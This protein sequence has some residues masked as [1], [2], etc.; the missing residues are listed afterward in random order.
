MVLAREEEDHNRINY[1][2]YVTP[3]M[4]GTA[5]D[6]RFRAK[7]PLLAWL[8]TVLSYRPP[9]FQA[10]DPPV[11]ST[12]K[13][14]PRDCSQCYCGRGKTSSRIVGGDAAD[15]KEYP[16]IVMLLYRG[17]FY[18]GGS[19]IN[20][21]YILTAAHCVLSFTPSQLLA[22]LYD[23]EHSE[24]VTR[25]IVKLY[26]HE[27]FSLDTF[28]NDIAL[29]KLQQPVDVGG[30]F[31]AICLPVNGRTYAGH[32]GTV[33]GWGKLGNGSLSQ[34]LQKAVVPIMSNMQCR[35]SNYRASRITDN[36]LCA[37]YAEGGRD[38]CQCNSTVH[39]MDLTSE[40]LT[41]PGRIAWNESLMIDPNGFIGKAPLLNSG[42]WTWITTMF[43]MPIFS[44]FAYRAA[45]RNCAPCSCGTNSN[46]SKIVGG[47]EAE[48]G[49]YPW[50]VALYY[51]NRFI[52]GGSLINDRYVLTAAHCVFGS[53][54]SR[55]RVKFLMHDRTEPKEDSFER[56]VSYI[57]T[58]WFLNVLVFITNDVALLK[59]NEPVPLGETI[60]PVCLPPE[61]DTYADR[62]GIVTGWGKRGDGTFP[63]RLQEVHVP[64]LGNADCHNQTQYFRFQ[65]NDRM[66][67]AGI[68]EGGKDSCQGDSGGPMHVFDADANRFVIAGVVSWGFGCA[69][70]RF[71]GI[72]ARV[73]RFI[74]W[75][76]FNT[77]DAFECQRHLHFLMRELLVIVGKSF[78]KDPRRPCLLAFKCP[79][80][81]T[82]RPRTHMIMNRSSSVQLKALWVL[83]LATLAAPLQAAPVNNNSS[84]SCDCVCGV[85]GR[86]NRIVGG[87]ET[88]AHQ[89]PWLAG[90]FRQG[91]LYCGASVVS[92]NF[93]VTAAHCV[94]S[95]EP[96]E[97][98]VYLGGHII[99]KDYTELRRVKRI[100]DHEDFDIF[101]FNN[102]IALLELDK[103][104]RY[105]PT[106]QPACLPDGSVMDFTG[107][108]GV[109]AGWGRVEEK[110]APSKTLRSVEVPIWSHE[111]CL[112]AG[113][114]SKKIS[115]NMMCA[116]Y[117]DGQKD[118]CQGDSGGPMHKMGL[119]GSMEVIGVVSWGRGCA[120][121]NLPGIYTR[122]V[123]YLPWIHQKLANECLCPPK[124]IARRI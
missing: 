45:P 41:V 14:P 112:D 51:N 101:T 40:N 23:V 26:G 63:V 76:N 74:S 37:G 108:I 93:L 75:I 56:K 91:K 11:S 123:N 20:D 117:H 57:M 42:V 69:Q 4:V 116:G 122:I 54:R 98:R 12:T 78:L 36:M 9:S 62:E 66:M 29:A 89:F 115:A 60:V 10:A 120:R 104:L 97:I 16:W 34:G 88:S 35:K 71:P 106:I 46:N 15:V 43:G 84:E 79:R 30:S 7:N 102:D 107:T 81:P 113:Y 83:M 27:R 111:Q 55:F 24:M 100:I 13:A 87:S 33:V 65:I 82:V 80:V 95:F 25:S 47:Q 50:M 22:K 70:P 18:C 92:R 17:S 49:R 59:L 64:I 32:N 85:G 2:I 38:A 99:A 48:I 21:R 96:S 67:C 61:G 72:Y 3:T 8:S 109:V 114:G 19:L 90:L 73:N 119:F 105:G 121:P 28:N 53:D 5:S 124:D 6:N 77:R 110:R 1:D 118:A 86:T 52:C 103:P 68:P 44:V 31:I 94:N 39:P 58:N